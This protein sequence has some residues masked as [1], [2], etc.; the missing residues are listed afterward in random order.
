MKKLASLT[1]ILVLAGC[2]L[3]LSHQLDQRFGAA[4][5]DNR[6]GAPAAAN[7]QS[8]IK[9]IIESRCVVCHGCY[10]A[11]CQLKLE[12]QAG[13]E[14]GANREKVYDGTRLLAANL[15]RLFEDANSTG[16]WRD[17]GFYPVLNERAQTEDAH[18]ASVL[19]RML[20]LKQ[21]HPLPSSGPLP[22]SFDFALDRNQQCP[23]DSEFDRYAE[24][25]PLAGMPYGL[26]GLNPRE[27]QLLSDWVAQGAHGED[28]A[29]AHQHYAAERDQWEHFLNGD[30]L[31]AQLV[32]RYIYEHLYLANIHFDDSRV[33]FRLVRSATPPGQPLLP[34]NTRRPFDDPDAD[35]VYY[36]LSPMIETVVAKNHLPYRFDAARLARWQQLFFAPHYEVSALPGY[37]A[38]VAANPFKAFRELPLKARYRFM[39]DQAQFTIGGFIKGPVC[40]GQTALNVINDQFWVFFVDPDYPDLAEMHDFLLNSSDQLSLPAERSSSAD[41]LAHW[42]IYSDLQMQYLQAQDLQLKRGLQRYG[43][44]SLEMIWQGDGTN[45]NAALT[46]FRHFD[47]AAVV[48]GLVGPEP[49]TA[50]VISYPL[51]ERIHYLLVAGFDVYGNLGHQLLT[52]TYMDFLRMEGERNFL[53]FLPPAAA[54][55]ELAFWYRG[56]HD[57]VSDYFA[58]LALHE[59]WTS[60]VPYQTDQPKREL[61]AL[62]A[63]HLDGVRNT[64]HTPS[65]NPLLATGISQSLE[66]LQRLSGN[67]LQW[68]PDTSLLLIEQPAPFAPQLVSMLRNRAHKNITSLLLEDRNLLP[69]E[70]TLTLAS[71]VLT[72]YPYALF[73]IKAGQL[74]AFAAALSGMASDAD[75]R[76]LRQDFGVLRNDP[77]FWAFSDRLHQLY[78]QAEP[79]SW[80]WLDYNRLS[81][82]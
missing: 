19:Y 56:A 72:Q 71:G 81:N 51:L 28:S 55:K 68:L 36:R 79:V 67:Q 62:L 42:L 35:R 40:R 34:I 21:Q 74:D 30:S 14:R 77:A 33:F 45:P 1:G 64:R 65:A 13:L 78:Q 61:L 46:V 17:K 26:P 24:R 23:A 2:S 25:F 3:L 11:P 22:D 41:P 5:S 43:G 50:W 49:K 38:T 16:Q 32:A 80:G 47:S 9:P 27:H 15:T 18:R 8:Q 44:P 82:P 53:M 4:H 6:P 54:R 59:T 73:H 75:Y 31:K 76:Q 57:S 60:R 12:S 70:D 37:A 29:L 66:K 39:L 63:A 69:E 52:R 7:Y 20:A 48:Q 10:D 58:Q